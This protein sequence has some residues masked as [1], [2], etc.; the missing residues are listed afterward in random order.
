MYIIISNFRSSNLTR[1]NLHN[2]VGSLL[3][4]NPLSCETTNCESRH[5]S[6]ELTPCEM[7]SRNNSMIALYSATLFDEFCKHTPSKDNT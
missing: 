4:Y 1:K 6:R 3:R 2:N 7:E 5:T